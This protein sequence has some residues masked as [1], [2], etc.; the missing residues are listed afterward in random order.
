MI[1]VV[2]KEMSWTGCYGSSEPG[3]SG[4][5]KLPCTG[6]ESTAEWIRKVIDRAAKPVLKEDSTLRDLARGSARVV[7]GQARVRYAVGAY[8]NVAIACQRSY[9]VPAE[10]VGSDHLADIDARL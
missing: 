1:G 3:M 4:Q 9:F 6:G 5:A 7:L 2:W 10:A 8:R